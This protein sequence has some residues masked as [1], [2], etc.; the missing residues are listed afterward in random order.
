M[1]GLGAPQKGPDPIGRGR[2]TDRGRLRQNG[3]EWAVKV[4]KVFSEE[5]RA[6]AFSASPLLLSLISLAPQCVLT[7]PIDV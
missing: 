4:E 7:D 5:S 1:G 6:G 2:E 3:G